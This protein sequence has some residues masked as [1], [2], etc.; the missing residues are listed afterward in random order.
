MLTKANLFEG[1]PFITHPFWNP[2]ANPAANPPKAGTA[3][4]TA[5]AAVENHETLAEAAEFRSA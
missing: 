1:S 2:T 3:T 5:C 4:E